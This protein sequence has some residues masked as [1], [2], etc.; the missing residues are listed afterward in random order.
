LENLY[1]DDDEEEEEEEIS[2]A[3]EITSKNVKSSA[4]HTVYVKLEP[5]K[6]WFD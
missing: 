5:H 2:G 6:S 1:Y 4:T 3:W